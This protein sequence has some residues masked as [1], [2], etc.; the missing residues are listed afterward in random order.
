MKLQEIA[1]AL[2]LDCDTEIEINGIQYD[3]RKITRGDMFVCLRGNAADG[4]Q[5]AEKAVSMG[6]VAL[7]VEE[8]VLG[9][10]VPQLK[11]ADTRRALA[12]AAETFFGHPQKSLKL[13]GLTGTNG[14]TTT[15]HLIKWILDRQGKKTGLIGTNHIIIGDRVI[16]A[17]HTTPESLEISSYLKEMVDCGCEYAVM[18][19]SSH[20][21]K[22]GR[23]S[24]LEFTAAAF[25]NLTQDHLDYHHDFADYLASKQ[26]LFRSLG[27]NAVAVVNYDDPYCKDFLAVSAVKP[28][29]FGYGEGAVYRS[30]DVKITPQGTTF[31]LDCDGTSYEVK[32][33]LLGDFNVYNVMNAIAVAR[34]LGIDMESILSAME[35]APQVHG[36]FERVQAEQGP[37]VVIDYAHSP[38]GLENI[39]TTANQMKQGRVILVFG[40]GGDRDK[41][42]RPIMGKIG[43]TMSDFAY[44][45]SDNPRTEDPASI[46]AMVEEGVEES[47]GA[48]EVIVDRREAIKT[49]ILNAKSEDLVVIAGKGHEDYQIIGTEKVHFDDFEEAEKALALYKAI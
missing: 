40:C 27:E 18:E 32:T 12:V 46:V 5:F 4:H 30:H 9:C 28:V 7:L 1:S 49:A 33:P 13:I 35:E 41:T 47:G 11:V 17:T 2:G 26:I 14:K 39:L 29:T 21:L 23:V 6:A 20:G 24:A 48:Y 45:T 25:T 36:R 43:G 15:T 8:D 34:G 3:S 37:T 44:V 31:T 38:D 10:D 42:K 16:P 22:Q 19:V